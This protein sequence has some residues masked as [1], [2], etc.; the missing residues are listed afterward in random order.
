MEGTRTVI[1]DFVELIFENSFICF[2]GDVYTG[3]EGIPTGNCV[4]RQIADITLHRMLFCE[5]K[6]HLTS[7]W[8]WISFWKR[9]IDD[10][11]GLWTGT[12]RQ[13]DLF[14]SKLNELTKPYGIQFGD[15]QIGRSVNF[16]DVTLMLNDDNTIEYKLY[17][18]DTDARLYLKT[19]SF[20]PAHVFNSV[21]FSQ[22]IRII[23][24]N[25]QDST[26][27][28][29]MAELKADLIRSGHHEDT[30]E[31]TE[32]LAV[33]R[34]IENDLYTD[35]QTPKPTCQQ[36]VYSVKYFKEIDQLK[37]LV[38]GVQPDIAELCGDVKVTFAIRKQPSIGNTIVRNRRLSESVFIPEVKTQKC[39]GPGCQSCPFMF[40]Y[41]EKIVI[42]GMILRLDFTLSCKDQHVIYVAQ[43]QLCNKQTRVYK[44]DAYFGQTIQEMHCRMNGHRNKFKIDSSLVFEKSA[45][46]MHCFLEHKDDFSMSN[47]KLGIVK[48]VKP[49][50]LDREETFYINKFRTNI[51]GLN[52]ISVVR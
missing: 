41:D 37:R 14:I 21:T 13:F 47:F 17:K 33:Q 46:A 51:W 18:K 20:H 28:E 23:Q 12:L 52:R 38:H 2:Q 22:M 30:V 35:H 44:E 27:V 16:L 11:I 25:S 24:R 39:G 32:P 8:K 5:V 45:L 15:S 4:S 19:D 31:E 42:N 26:C 36:V 6:P 43:C 29:D 7:L 48:K 40:D 1:Y 50:D 3:K 49:T 9:F 10:I 34:A